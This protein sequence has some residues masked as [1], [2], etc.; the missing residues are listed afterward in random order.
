MALSDVVG[1][2]VVLQVLVG[3]GVAVEVLGGVVSVDVVG[4]GL[5][6]EVGI[7][8]VGSAGSPLA[9]GGM[10]VGTS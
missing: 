10:P 7:C 6:I 8:S 9:G 1:T 5:M 4:A 2:G 3:A